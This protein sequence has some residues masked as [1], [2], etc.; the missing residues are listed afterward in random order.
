[1]QSVQKPCF[2][3]SDLTNSLGETCCINKYMKNTSSADLRLLS[4]PE[5]SDRRRDNS[6]IFLSAVDRLFRS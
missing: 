1:M 5:D 6:Q 3:N 4:S 2:K